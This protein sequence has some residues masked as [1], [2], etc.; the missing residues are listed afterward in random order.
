MHIP[1]FG[2]GNIEAPYSYLRAV[3]GEPNYFNGNVYKSDVQWKIYIQSDPVI[4]ATVY[5]Y[6]NG[7]N[8]LGKKG[9]QVEQITY[10][11]VGGNHG[12]KVKKYIGNRLGI[13]V[14]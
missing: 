9:K 12:E 3:L 7:K 13:P 14:E 6:K 1:T 8:H 11:S 2:V 5:N 10:W 4:V